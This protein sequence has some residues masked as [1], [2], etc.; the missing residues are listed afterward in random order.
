MK[1]LIILLLSLAAISLLVACGGEDKDTNSTATSLVSEQTLSS[2]STDATSEEGTSSEPGVSSEASPDE[3]EA[4]SD[5]SED[6][7]DESTDTQTSEPEESQPD[8]SSQPEESGDRSLNDMNAAELLNYAYEKYFA[9]DGFT[10]DTQ[11]KLNFSYAGEKES[12]TYSSNVKV[13]GLQGNTPKFISQVTK[14]FEGNQADLKE[15]YVNGYWFKESK[16][17]KEKAAVTLSG[18]QE[19]LIR[20]IGAVENL[21]GNVFSSVKKSSSGDGWLVTGTGLT[22]SS[23]KQILDG[24]LESVEFGATTEEIKLDKFTVET[25]INQDGYITKQTVNCTFTMDYAGVKISFALEM[26]TEYTNHNSTA[27]EININPNDYKDIN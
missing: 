25:Y 14:T 27:V 3:S 12:M 13:E 17:G 20:N 10:A 1:K 8:E 24:I 22:A 2:E 9:L 16:S 11:N 7:P 4:S 26:K 18:M 21:T 6:S 15:I 5:E 19:I 23:S